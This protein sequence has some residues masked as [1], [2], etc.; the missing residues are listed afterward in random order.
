MELDILEL[1]WRSI[2][3]AYAKACSTV[4]HTA[5]HG[6]ALPGVS[7]AHEREERLVVTGRRRGIA[8]CG[9]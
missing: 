1:L 4:G 3:G 5:A 8:R 2:S 9:T 7:C 6:P